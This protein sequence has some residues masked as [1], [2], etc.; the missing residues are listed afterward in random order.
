MN[1]NESS[2]V[3]SF[4][5]LVI[6]CLVVPCN[7][8]GDLLDPVVSRTSGLPSLAINALG[9]QEFKHHIFTSPLD[10]NPISR[11]L[12]QLIKTIIRGCV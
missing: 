1:L 3:K 2:T 10:T 4:I 7:V 12:T 11:G 5:A 6:I 9:M 8:D